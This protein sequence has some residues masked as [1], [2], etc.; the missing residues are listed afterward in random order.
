MDVLPKQGHNSE[1]AA[2]SE[3]RAQISRLTKA[4]ATLIFDYENPKGN[5]E[6]RSHVYKLRQTRAAVE[7]AR[8]EEKAESLAYGRRV[9]EQA[10]AIAAQID[11]MIDVHA[12]PLEEIEHREKG[13]IERHET[14]LIE[15]IAAGNRTSEQ[16]MDIP[17]DAMRDRLAEIEA[18]P[19]DESHWDEFALQ[20]AQAKDASLTQMREAVAKREQHDAEQAELETLRKEAEARKQADHE[21]AIRKESAQRAEDEARQKA[22]QERQRVETEATREREA[23]ERRE[24]EL[25]LAAE[26]AERGKVEAEQ[27][28]ANAEKEANARAEREQIEKAEREAAKAAEREADKKHHS[29]VNRKAVAAFVKGGLAEDTAKQAVTLI[30][31]K[32][33]PNVSIS[34]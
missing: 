12:K 25:R 17:L 22:E 27:R 11:E 33:V 5:K 13:R 14:N 23:G 9:D 32:S 26:T 28:A 1:I 3:F 21:E 2:Y 15:I 8:K 4:N 19:I 6:A 29:A 16:W 34:Y 30:A 20:A 7:K 18:E 10:K 24:L 31:Q